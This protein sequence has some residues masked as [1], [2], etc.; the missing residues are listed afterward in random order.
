MLVEEVDDRDGFV[1]VWAQSAEVDAPAG[2][3]AVWAP[4]LGEVALLAFGAGVDGDLPPGSSTGS[5]AVVGRGH[6]RR[7]VAG[8]PGG[9]P[10]GR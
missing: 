8:P 3:L 1:A 2:S 5:R 6:R 10:A 4:L 7:G 9:L